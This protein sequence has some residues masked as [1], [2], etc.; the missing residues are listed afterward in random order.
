MSLMSLM[1]EEGLMTRELLMTREVLKERRGGRFLKGLPPPFETVAGRDCRRAF[2][3]IAPLLKP[4]VGKGCRR[5]VEK[6]APPLSMIV[7]EGR[8]P[9][10][11][12]PVVSWQT[13]GAPHLI[14]HRR[15]SY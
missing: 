8:D 11:L 5:V 4:V 3:R 10:V 2:G 1:L 6:V 15:M 13:S 7:M 9:P 14:E 12:F